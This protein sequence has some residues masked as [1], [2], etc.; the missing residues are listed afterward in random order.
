[1][2]KAVS[3]PQTQTHKHSYDYRDYI[4]QSFK[5]LIGR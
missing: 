2:F 3:V 4:E 1:M 5:A